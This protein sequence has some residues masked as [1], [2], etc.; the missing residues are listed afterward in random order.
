MTLSVAGCAG[1]VST[2]PGTTSATTAQTTATAKGNGLK[3]GTYVSEQK[4]HNG[5]I[6]VEVKVSDT[7]IESISV[8]SGQET[9]GLGDAAIEKMK[10]EIIASQGLGVDTVTGATVSSK[11][12]LAGVTDAMTQAGADVE[13]LK[14]IK[15]AKSSVKAV[16]MEADIVI[17]GAGGAGMAAAAEAAEAGKKVIIVEK[18]PIVGGNTSRATGGINAA[19]TSIQKAGIKDDVDTFYKDTFTGGKEEND[20][21]LLRILVDKSSSAVDWLNELGAGLSRVTLSGGAT[22]PRIHTPADGSAIGPVVVRVLSEKLAELKVSILTETKAVA[23][24]EK[25]GTAIGVEAE[26]KEGEKFKIK[27]GAV[28]MATGGFSAN[29]EMVQS[30]R[31]DLVG[32]STTNHIGATGDGINMAET[33]NAGLDDIQFIQTHPTTDPKTGYMFTEALRGD[34]AILLNQEGKRFTDE[35]LTRD[36]V[37]ANIL[38]QTGGIAYLVTNEAMRLENAA[39]AGYVTK[40][41]AV[42]CK[43]LA[44]AAVYLGVSE[45]VVA[46]TMAKYNKAIETGKDEEFGRAHLTKSLAQGPF[47]LLKVTPSIHH[48]MGGL[49]IDGQAH[50]LNKNGNI[51]KGFYAAG[52]VTGGVHGANRIGGNAVTD[53]IVFGRIA[54]QTAASELK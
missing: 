17:I 41:Y 34:G 22:N 18:M 53:I 27:A 28:I 19:G 43:T 3:A 42:E 39:L 45:V 47:Y 33:L 9:K 2:T 36:V 16:D 7:V 6:K 48:T 38:K 14:T 5:M 44:D 26:N 20:P 10:G 52:E 40:G 21:A 35:L 30:F 24:L 13:K 32:F 1:N 8:D 31:A 11:A 23:I 4:G 12:F 25:D 46:D 37:S 49:K 50:V 29:A 54:G 51:I 15:P